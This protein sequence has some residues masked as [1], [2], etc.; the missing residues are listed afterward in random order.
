MTELRRR[1]I[2]DM[3]L[4]GFSQR[5]QETYLYAVS[6]LARHFKKSPERITNQELRE[7]FLYHKD[8]YARNTTT[9]AL[10][11]IKFFYEKTL[12]KQMPVLN[13]TRLPRQNKLPVVLTKEEVWRVL[14]NIRVLRHRACLTLIYSCGLRL[15]EATRLKVNQIDSKRMLIHIQQAKGRHDRY[16]PLPYSTLKLL[17]VHYKLHRNR[18]LVFPAPGRGELRESATLKP[19]PDSSIQTVFKKSLREVGIHKDAHV[20][21][22]R[23]SYA[24]HL[25]EAG[26]DIRI[27]QEYLGHQSIQTTMI[28]TQLTPLINQGVYERINHLMDGL[29]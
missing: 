1:M 27:I 4:H 25:L 23:H 24:T 6:K 13:L 28:Y 20:H 18:L 21:T 26:V 2:E 22:L 17:R 7:Y 14:Q 19:L 8:R 15:K 29:S 9:I 12:Q 3:K 10:C 16:V 5:T 11:G